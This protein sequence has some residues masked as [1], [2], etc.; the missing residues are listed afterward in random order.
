MIPLDMMGTSLIPLN[1]LRD[2]NIEIY[3]NQKTKYTGREFLMDEI[4]PKL[5]CKWND[6][7]HFTAVEPRIVKE[8]LFASGAKK[9]PNASFYKIPLTLFNLER[10]VLYKY[11]RNDGKF[12]EDEYEHLNKDNFPVSDSM[13]GDT[14]EYYRSCYEQGK[15]PLLFHRVPHILT[16][17][18]IDI[19]RCEIL[20]W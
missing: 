5:N 3:E 15:K 18:D 10:T 13:S 8:S 6:V 2:V 20:D 12:M 9:L 14:L 7:L 17:D 4:V 16:M 1:R 19:S 11:T